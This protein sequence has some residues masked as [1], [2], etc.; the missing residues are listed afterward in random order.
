M[1]R[2]KERGESENKVNLDV[3]CIV[4]NGVRM[5]GKGRDGKGREGEREKERRKENR[6]E[7]NRGKRRREDEGRVIEVQRR[8]GER[9][10]SEGDLNE[11][12]QK[13]FSKY[14]VQHI[15]YLIITQYFNCDVAWNMFNS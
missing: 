3:T 9:R 4:I 6:R 11:D 7:R 1:H 8:E 13:A 2:V 14:T 12:E 15:V 10:K 5:K